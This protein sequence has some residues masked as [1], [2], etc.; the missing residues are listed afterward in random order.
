MA[1]K[2]GVP[3]VPLGIG[4]TERV[5][6]RGSKFI[7][8]SKVHIVVG[9]PIMPPVA[10]D[11]ARGP[12]AAMKVVSDQLHDELQRLFDAAQARV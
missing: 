11:G 1:S 9:P 6:K 8:P 10:A 12:R 4:G 2:A 5:M 3:I 7:R